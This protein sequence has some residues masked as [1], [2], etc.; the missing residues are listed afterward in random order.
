MTLVIRAGSPTASQQLIPPAIDTVERLCLWCLKVLY[1]LYRAKDFYLVEGD[2]PV[3]QVSRN[4][5]TA[6]N[7]RL[8]EAFTIYFTID[9]AI[10]S[11]KT[12]KSWMFGDEI[13]SAVANSNYNSD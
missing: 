8:T 5:F 12:K 13:S 2:V 6:A 11:D 3:K 4:Q 9:E 7:G 10:A 1:S